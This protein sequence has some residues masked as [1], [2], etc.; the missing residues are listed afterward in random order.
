MN[1]SELHAKLSELIAQGKGDRP[2]VVFRPVY[3]RMT[4]P[5]EAEDMEC[6]DEIE[7]GICLG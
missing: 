4:M 3:G 6:I 7:E 2:V 5:E 1:V